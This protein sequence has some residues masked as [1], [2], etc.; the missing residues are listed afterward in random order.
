MT[1]S[2]NQPAP[3]FELP[4]SELD[5][6]R[7]GKKYKLSDLRGKP[8]VLA[9]YPLDFSP[10]CTNENTCFRD[11]LKDFEQLGA[12]VLGIS[13]DSVWTHAAFAKSLGLSYPLLADF[14][15]K[16]AVAKSYG[17]YLDDKGMTKRGTVVIDRNGKVAW[18]KEQPLG[19][20]RNNK[21][22][23]EALQKA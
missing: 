13:V 5:N 9:F 7:P 15:P 6:G 19:E 8:V 1:I 12:Q 4:S 14:H 17:M 23:L 3:D 10:V 21:E 22:V 2:V 16:G 18:I 20:A 11:D